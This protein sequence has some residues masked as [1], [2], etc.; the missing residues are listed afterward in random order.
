MRLANQANE[1]SLMTN[2][3]WVFQLFFL[4]H[5]LIDLYIYIYYIHIMEG[6]NSTIFFSIKS[7]V[8]HVFNIEFN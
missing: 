2:Y 3:G 5:T 7:I 8:V 1:T 6:D 4:T